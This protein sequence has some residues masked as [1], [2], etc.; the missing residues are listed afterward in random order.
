MSDFENP[1]ARIDALE[2][3]VAHQDQ[4][5]EDLNKAVVEQ[6][7]QIDSLT[8]QFAIL[9]DRVREAEEQVGGAPRTEPPPPHY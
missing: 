1:Q 7:K 2:M 8:R 4:I 3:R 9:V 6:W 5:I